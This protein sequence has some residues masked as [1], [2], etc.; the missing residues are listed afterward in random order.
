MRVHTCID[1]S[2]QV[3]HMHAFRPDRKETNFLLIGMCCGIPP[4]D[5][6]R[7]DWF[8]ANGMHG[9]MHWY[10]MNGKMDQ[11]TTRSPRHN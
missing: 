4:G 6:D 11:Y 5:T 3:T 1:S 10:D 9:F 7:Q 2:E 8:G